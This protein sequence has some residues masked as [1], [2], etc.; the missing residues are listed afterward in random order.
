VEPPASAGCLS[1]EV[2]GAWVAGLLPG[3]EIASVEA[4]VASCAACLHRVGLAARD[5]RARP[6]DSTLADPGGAAGVGL[7]APAPAL[8]SWAE[9]ESWAEAAR[10]S[11]PGARAPELLAGRYELLARIAQGGMGE[12]YRGRDRVTGA[13]V[14]IKRLRS[15][16]G[17]ADAELLARFTREAEILRRLDHP[18]IVQMLD[19]VTGS[20]PGSGADGDEQHSIIMEYVPGGSL[21]RELVRQSML[22][23]VDALLLALE[24]AD[25][26]CQAHRLNVI[27]RDIKPENVLLANDGTVRLSDFG[28]ARIGERSFTAPGTVLGTVA[29]L[30][31]E[32]LWGHEVDVRTDLW[33]LGVMLFEMLSGVRPFVAS[34]PGATLTAILQQPVPELAAFC[35]SAGPALVD[36]T[37]RLLQKDRDQRIATAAEVSSAIEAILESLSAD[38]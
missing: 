3:A 26:L 15:G 29:Y 18:N 23:Q 38:P 12:V 13:D 2:L 25:A 19:I 14:A 35:P 1:P 8:G 4:H 16:Q 21:R 24:V 27:H 11:E 28:L 36:L 10:P 20:V 17:A 6:L 32:V 7:A 34:S 31:P 30:S 22:P 33:S 37:H 5:D 9:L